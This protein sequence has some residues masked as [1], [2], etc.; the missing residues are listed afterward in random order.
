MSWKKKGGKKS[1]V[2]AEQFVQQ[3]A[4]SCKYFARMQ[5]TFGPRIVVAAN[6][7]QEADLRQGIGH[8][9]KMA[10][11]ENQESKPF[12]ETEAKTR[13]SDTFEKPD[14]QNCQPGS[15][16][17]AKQV[18]SMHPLANAIIDHLNGNEKPLKELRKAVEK[19]ARMDNTARVNLKTTCCVC[20]REFK[21][22][23]LHGVKEECNDFV[24]PA[25]NMEVETVGG[26][27]T[28]VD[29]DPEKREHTLLV[30][31]PGQAPSTVTMSCVELQEAIHKMD[32]KKLQE[33]LDK[34]HKKYKCPAQGC[35]DTKERN[36]Q[37]LLDHLDKK[38]GS[39]G[40]FDLGSLQATINCNLYQDLLMERT[41]K[42]R[43]VSKNKQAKKAPEEGVK[44]RKKGEDDSEGGSSGRGGRGRRA[45]GRG[46]GS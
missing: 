9:H 29:F 42:S 43:R 44:K 27:G 18:R 24:E 1:A 31:K 26:L 45:R 5:K 6:S 19:Y 16:G 20:K 4:S 32:E 37:V 25:I 10:A 35:K 46:S 13:A 23:D 40:T 15:A 17:E 14:G 7:D 28:V 34:K 30:R 41:R 21:L 12:F 39:E 3:A 22:G 33:V 2:T 8:A 36:L 11:R 38:H